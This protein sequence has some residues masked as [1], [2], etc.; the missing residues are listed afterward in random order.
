MRRPWSTNAGTTLNRYTLFH[1][2]SAERNVLGVGIMVRQA[3]VPTM[4]NLG[5]LGPRLP[6]ARFRGAQRNLSVIVAHAPTGAATETD[7]KAFYATLHAATEECGETDTKVVLIDANAGPSTDRQGW[8]H[9]WGPHGIP[10]PKDPTKDPNCVA[11]A[12]YCFSHNLLIGTRYLT[13]T[14]SIPTLRTL[15]NQGIWIMYS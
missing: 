8:S 4:M 10:Y 1:T 5:L 15:A 11:F 7:R 12:E 3:L 13:S 14:H 6:V 9:I 2:E